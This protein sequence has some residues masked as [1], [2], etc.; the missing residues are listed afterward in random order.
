MVPRNRICLVA[1]PGGV[2]ITTVKSAIELAHEKA[3]FHEVGYP[4]DEAAFEDYYVVHMPLILNGWKSWMIR[5]VFRI[6]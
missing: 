6:E 2:Y 1:D 5:K 4:D 3:K